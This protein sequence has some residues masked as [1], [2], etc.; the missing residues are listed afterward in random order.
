MP[1]NVVVNFDV[2]A[3]AS[4]TVSVFGKQSD[5]PSTNVIYADYKLPVSTLYKASGDALIKFQG[6]GSNIVAAYDTFTTTENQV[7]A[8]LELILTKLLDARNATPFNSTGYTNVN[9]TN[10][11]S[12]GELALASYAH[13]IFGHVQ[14]TAA[15]TNDDEFVTFMDSNGTTTADTTKANIAR[16]LAAKIRSG[17]TSTEILNIAKQVIGQDASRA[18]NVDNDVA[19]PNNWQSL[20]WQDGDII[21]F[22]ITL[23]DPTIKYGA[24]ASDATAAP[25]YNGWTASGNDGQQYH[26]TSIS[27]IKYNVRVILGDGYGGVNYLTPPGTALWATSCQ[28]TNYE[29]GN[30]IT[31]DKDGNV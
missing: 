4:G 12:F 6:D 3:D 17:L 14:A 31:T 16:A 5:A 28:G 19:A 10:Y 24:S 15:I 13:N 18:K 27:D 9:H 1:A 20:E 29:Q 8:S 26:P 11:T 7:A 21:Y 22:Q 23:R 30:S 25:D 2:N